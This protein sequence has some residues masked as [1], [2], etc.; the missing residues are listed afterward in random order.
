MMIC[1]AAGNSY[2]KRFERMGTGS[3]EESASNENTAG[4]SLPFWDAA[5]LAAGVFLR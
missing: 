3:R 1:K 4:N 2:L 5:S